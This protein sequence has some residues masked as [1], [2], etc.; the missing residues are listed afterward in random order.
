MRWRNFGFSVFPVLDQGNK[1]PALPWTPYMKRIAETHEVERWWRQNPDYGIGIACGAVSGGLE[2]T[3]LEGRACVSESLDRIVDACIAEGVGDL[4]ESFVDNGYVESTPSGGIHLLY[5]VTNHEIP[6]NTKIATRPETDD[7]RAERLQ[8]SPNSS[9]RHIPVTLA[10]TRGEG[11]FVIVAPTS[12]KSH[13]TGDAWTLLSGEIGD[14]PNISWGER[15][16]LHAAIRKALHVE[17]PAEPRI[18][19]KSRPQLPSTSSRPGDEWASRVSWAEILEPHGWQYHSNRGE[20]ELWTRPGKAVRDGHSATVN[21]RG[22]DT[23]KV[24]S[25]DAYPFEPEATYS[26]FGA[27]ALLNHGGDFKEATKELARMGFGSKDEPEGQ[28]LQGLTVPERGE[29]PKPR[30][31]IEEDTEIGIADYVAKRHSDDYRYVV[32]EKDWRRYVNGSWRP[33]GGGR[34]FRTAVKSVV[35]KYGDRVKRELA[36]A[37][38]N[39]EADRISAAKK[40]VAFY[41]RTA[42]DKGV[43]ALVNLTADDLKIEAVDMNPDKRLLCLDNGT[44]DLGS[45]EFREHRPEDLLTKRISVSYDPQA[46]AP[47]WEKYLEEVL[48]DPDVRSY[49]QRAVGQTMLGRVVDGVFFVLHGETGCGKSQ[50]VETLAAAFG[51]YSATAAADTFRIR[52]GAPDAPTTNMHFL[53]G[54]RFVSTS[55][56]KADTQLDEELIKRVTGDDKITSREVYQSNH[57][58]KPEFT[59]WMATNFLPKLNAEDSAIWRRVKPIHFPN[60]FVNGER[61]REKGLAG[62]MIEEELPGIFNWI[63]AGVEAYRTFGLDDIEPVTEAIKAH[64]TESDTVSQFLTEDDHVEVTGNENDMVG[65][66]ALYRRYSEWCDVNRVRGVLGPKRF[67]NRLESLGLK[68]RRL[69]SGNH[70]I[71]VKINMVLGQWARGG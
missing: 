56:S 47:R 58:W 64:R 32:E 45:M 22:G 65:A 59:L 3:E 10:E 53:R 23:L 49:V 16:L 71:G 60:S 61:P 68:S 25:S 21:Y 54:A 69:A 17:S 67:A 13:P 48:P 55:E 33:D 20:E 52:N 11:G 2:L 29:D 34:G 42:T 51:E 44:Y 43:R 63:L 19:S 24:F 50:F 39:S 4:W 57:T 18:E 66:T 14:V 70:R 46:R 62:K 8:K 28:R 12:G 1:K 5:R 40:N 36:E 38:D 15:E 37:Y 26:K 31:R 27:W 7:E 30:I 41:Q 35:R 9:T 6:G